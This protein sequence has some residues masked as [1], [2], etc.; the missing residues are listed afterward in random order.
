MTIIDELKK[1]GWSDEG[2]KFLSTRLN[3]PV[4]KRIKNKLLS[5]DVFENACSLCGYRGPALDNHHIH[6]RK[7]SSETITVCAN[8]HREIHAGIRNV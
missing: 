7:V 5:N 6:G 8:C 2:A 1:M 3:N 4:L